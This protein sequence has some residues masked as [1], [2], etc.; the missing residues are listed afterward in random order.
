MENTKLYNPIQ[1][2]DNDYDWNGRRDDIMMFPASSREAEKEKREVRDGMDSKQDPLRSGRPL[3]HSFR[4]RLGSFGKW[5]HVFLLVASLWIIPA[6]AV[7]VDFQ[8]CLSESAQHDTPLQLQLVPLVMNA[9]FNTTDPSH[10]LNIT[11]WTNVSGSM[12]GSTQYILPAP[13]SSYW[14]EKNDTTVGGKIEDNPN[15]GNSGKQLLTTLFS[16]VGVLTY[17]PYNPKVGQ[18]FCD[19]V[20]NATCPFGPNFHSNL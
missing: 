13:N 3:T 7:F 10:N 4:R 19:Q 11:V 12:V 17:T 2:R 6:S 14:E 5:S 9:V 20:N 1:D 16:K 15:A 8:N 18:D